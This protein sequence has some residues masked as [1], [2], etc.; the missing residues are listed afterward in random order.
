MVFF[1][2]LVRVAFVLGILGAAVDGLAFLV[3]VGVVVLVAAMLIAAR[4]WSTPTRRRHM[5][6]PAGRR[7]IPTGDT[8]E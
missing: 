1:F 5:R 2:I 8:N 6:W 3:A 4:R 7:E